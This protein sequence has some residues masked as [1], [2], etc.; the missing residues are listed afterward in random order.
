MERKRGERAGRVR[1]WGRGRE[2]ERERWGGEE[3]ESPPPL[4]RC[5]GA[6]AAAVMR[7]QSSLAGVEKSSR[8]WVSYRKLLVDDQRL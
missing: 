7:V 8:E 5:N 1:R 2:K 6:E 3:R 4:C